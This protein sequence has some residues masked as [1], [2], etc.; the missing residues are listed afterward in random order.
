MALQS[1]SSEGRLSGCPRC[2]VGFSFL[3]GVPS[4]NLTKSR[5]TMWNTRG[6]LTIMGLSENVG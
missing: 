4:G 6:L 5:D 1:V 3:I 2:L